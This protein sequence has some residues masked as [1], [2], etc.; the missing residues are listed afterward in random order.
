MKRINIQEHFGG[1]VE[2]YENL[3]TRLVPH[4]REQHQIIR[5]LLPLDVGKNY[6]VLDLGCGNGLLSALI[7][8]QFPHAFLV[9][10]DI[11]EEMLESYRSK[12]SKMTSSLKTIQ[13]DYRA[14]DFGN[15]Y[16]IIVSGMTLHH[17]T[18]NERRDFYPKLFSAMNE[19]GTYI[20]NDIIVDEDPQIAEDQYGLWKRFMEANG[21]DSEFWYAKHREKDH[22]PT[23]FQQMEWLKLA[24]FSEVGC[25]WRYYNFAITKGIK[26]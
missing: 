23:L 13:G 18:L 24:G 6:K 10:F 9:G 11:T 3:M 16:D 12:I 20:S 1:Q 8:E 14:D 19:G 4:C 2:I 15:G 21:E 7:L 26:V 17:L 5:S 22:P 25:Y